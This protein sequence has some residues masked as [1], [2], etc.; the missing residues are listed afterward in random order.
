MVSLG[1]CDKA[2]DRVD[3]EPRGSVAE[4]NEIL[5]L[6]R[7]IDMA[8]DDE[9][10]HSLRQRKREELQ[11]RDTR[12]LLT[13]SIRWCVVDG[14]HTSFVLGCGCRTDRI[15]RFHAGQQPRNELIAQ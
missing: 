10:E 2:A 9:A 1:A 7:P 6:F 11:A 15:L 13:R 3:T 12:A 14:T 4:V 5:P 8:F